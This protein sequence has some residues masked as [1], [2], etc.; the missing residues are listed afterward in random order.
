MSHGGPRPCLNIL[1]RCTGCH[2]YQG[3]LE[4]PVSAW[5]RQKP[6]PHIKS[7]PPNH[8]LGDMSGAA[9]L[10]SVPLQDTWVTSGA[11]AGNRLSHSWTCRQPTQPYLDLPAPT[12]PCMD[13]P[14]RLPDPA[15]AKAVTNRPS[16]M[17]QPQP[18]LL[19]APSP[20]LQTIALTPHLD[21]LLLCT[22][23]C[24]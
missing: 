12:K 19:P 11:G 15:A 5:S 3:M 14:A 18:P 21:K 6:P 16:P 23:N 1:P 24:C 22:F 9:F 10:C 2:S 7:P 17:R 4:W 8:N 13:L 20:P